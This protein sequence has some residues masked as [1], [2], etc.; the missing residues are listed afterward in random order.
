MEEGV[1]G[2]EGGEIEKKTEKVRGAFL[3]KRACEGSKKI[4]RNSFFLLPTHLGALA[5]LASGLAGGKGLALR[6]LL[7]GVDLFF[8]EVECRRERERERVRERRG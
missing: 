2:G 5:G 3:K 6:A 4:T 8:V 1:G 7:G